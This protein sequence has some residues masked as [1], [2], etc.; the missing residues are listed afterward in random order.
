VATVHNRMPVILERKAFEPWI[1]PKVKTAPVTAVTA[2]DV[3]RMYPVSRPVNSPKNDG[4]E[5]I[6]PVAETRT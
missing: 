5:C 6:T 1:D 4:P 3:L 2:E